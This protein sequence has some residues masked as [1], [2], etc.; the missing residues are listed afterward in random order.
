MIPSTDPGHLA[1]LDVGPLY[2]RARLAGA[3]A[4]DLCRVANGSAGAFVDLRRAISQ[5]HDLA[6]S[7][8]ILAAAGGAALGPEG[9][10]IT[11]TP[12]PHRAYHLVAAANQAQ[13]RTL[14]D[15][16]QAAELRP[17]RP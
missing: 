4:V 3:T 7:L 13:A 8:A 9:E 1:P 2:P 12:D 10:P 6:A 5:A 16:L 17:A 11:L 15:R 14:L